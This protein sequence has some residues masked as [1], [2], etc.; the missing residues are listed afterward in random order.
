LKTLRSEIDEANRKAVDRIIS[1]EAVLV[2]LMPARKAIPGFKNNLITHAGPPIS[3]E[4]MLKVQKIAVINAIISEGLADTPQR[5]DRLV[6]RHEV[7]VESNHEYGNVSGMC[8]V[9]SAR[10]LQRECCSLLL[11]SIRRS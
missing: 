4:R 5:A 8:G 7:C 3:W 9:T 6:S 2:D 1:A 11:W 10:A